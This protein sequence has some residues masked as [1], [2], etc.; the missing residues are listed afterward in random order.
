MQRGDCKKSRIAPLNA[1]SSSSSSVTA[2]TTI[3]TCTTST[4]TA[5]RS[6]AIVVVFLISLCVCGDRHCYS[7]T[8]YK[9]IWIS[10]PDV[11]L[12]SEAELKFLT[13]LSF[14][15]YSWLHCCLSFV[16]YC[17]NG[18]CEQKYG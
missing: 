9:R 4:T 3:A 6:V 12:S 1:I 13:F 15:D 10:S 11:N 17:N 14:E 16:Y 8:K 5:T 7:S 2:A 18:T